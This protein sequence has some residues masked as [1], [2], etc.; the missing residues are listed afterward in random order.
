MPPP[1]EPQELPLRTIL[2]IIGLSMLGGLAS[3]FERVRRQDLHAHWLLELVADILY[4]L[5]AGF[6]AWY[7][8]IALGGCPYTAAAAAILAGH[9][10]AR[11]LILLQRALLRRFGLGPNGNGNKPSA[12]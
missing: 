6:S 5:A 10:G 8:A 3:F 1:I 12:A 2:L 7:L 11:W 9:L 4:S